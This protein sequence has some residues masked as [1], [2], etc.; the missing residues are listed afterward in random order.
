MLCGISP[1]FA[2]LFPIGGQIAHVLRT[3]APCAIPYCYGTRTRLACVKHAASVRSEPGSNSRLKPVAWAKKMPRFA[4]RP[5]YPSKLLIARITQSIRARKPGWFRTDSGTSYRLSKSVP[6]CP[7]ERHY[8]S[9]TSMAKTPPRVNSVSHPNLAFSTAFVSRGTLNSWH[10][11]DAS[12]HPR[13][14]LTV[15]PV[16]HEPAKSRLAADTCGME[17]G[18]PFVLLYGQ[19]CVTCREPE[20]A[21]SFEKSRP[22]CGCL[23]HAEK[24][25]SLSYQAHTI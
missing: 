9:R 22:F 23:E 18:A 16:P 1:A 3:R 14:T 10:R 7:A 24:N 5:A 25:P 4:P 15:C 17:S 19:A 13:T 21:P 2:G 11:S 8:H 12:Q 20:K 6:P